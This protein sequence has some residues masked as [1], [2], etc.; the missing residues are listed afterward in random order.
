[1]FEPTAPQGYVGN[2]SDC[3]D[4]NA[5]TFPGAAPNDSATECMRDEDGDDYGDDNPPG[6]VTPGTD[7]DDLNAN[8]VDMCTPCMPGEFICNG[9][10]DSAQCNDN[11]TGYDVVEDCQYGCDDGNG[12]CWVELMVDADQF[13]CIDIGQGETYVFNPSVSGGDG[14]YTYNWDPDAEILGPDNVANAIGA[15]D[16]VTTYTLNVTDGE[17]NFGSDDVTIHVAGVQWNILTDCDFYT[18]PD[19][20]GDQSPD[21]NHVFSNGGTVVCN[22]QNSL[23]NAFVCPNVYE[24]ARIIGRMT[25]T[26]QAGDDDSIGFV[27]GWQDDH[28][29]YILSWKQ[30]D[31]VTPTFGLWPAG[32]IIKRIQAP[33]AATITA[34][35]ILEPADTANSTLIAGPADV[36][37]QGWVE[38]IEYQVDV[39]YGSPTTDIT[40]S[41]INNPADP[42]DDVEIYSYTVND[43]TFPSGQF[44]TFDVS[45]VNACNGPWT[46]T[47]L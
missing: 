4:T 23:P 34:A 9:N 8:I 19:P 10:D 41:N 25:V 35:D 22:T 46:S 33:P 15:P 12:V 31:Q 28:N 13:V 2:N 14:N 5:D 6:G 17:G 40:V 37:N 16:D 21:P 27:W 30:A 38:G 18:F 44:G 47:C 7:C 32:V 24:Q 3:D 43:G 20:F 42:M 29:F 11:G 36:Y 39:S 1:V 26:D 45:Q